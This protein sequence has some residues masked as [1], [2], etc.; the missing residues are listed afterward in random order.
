MQVEHWNGI[1]LTVNARPRAGMLMAGGVSVGRTLTD[2]CE[3]AAAVPESLFG[4]TILG[5]ANSNVWLPLQY[6]RQQSPFQAQV[7][8]IGAYTVPRIGVQVSGAF[9]SL[10]GPLVAANYN[11]PNAAV[12]GSLGR[13]LSGSAANISVNLVEPGS[14]YGE[15]MNQ[16]DLRVAKILRLGRAR[17]GVNLDLYNLFNSNAVLTQNNTFAGATPWQ[18]PQSILLPRFAKVSV[19]VDF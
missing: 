7:K 16:L 18:Q 12:A 13:S 11:A 17:T 8:L 6:C 14:M 2:V 4:A 19:Q 3:I 9:Q 10:P 15:R 1:D 5:N